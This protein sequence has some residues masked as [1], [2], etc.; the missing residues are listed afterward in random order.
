MENLGRLISEKA[1]AD[2][3]RQERQTAGKERLSAPLE[4]CVSQIAGDTVR[5]SFRTA[6]NNSQSIGLSD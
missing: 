5:A 1:S 2:A 4:A 6:E 3:Q